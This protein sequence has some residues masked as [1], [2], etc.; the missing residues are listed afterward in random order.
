ML[1]QQDK[2]ACA[3]FE[4]IGWKPAVR[5]YEMW[6]EVEGEGGSHKS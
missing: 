5:Q 4:S 3:F 6:Y 2:G 1:N